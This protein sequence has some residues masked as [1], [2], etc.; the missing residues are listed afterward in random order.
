[1]RLLTTGILGMLVAAFAVAIH[2][3]DRPADAGVGA[4]QRAN[5]LLRVP[6]E[7]VSRI[8]IERGTS[9]VVLEQREGAWFFASPEVDRVD[10]RIVGSLLDELNHLGVV[11][12]LR[13]GEGDLS[14]V[15][16]GVQGDEAIQVLLAG[17]DERGRAFEEKVTLG[18]PAPRSG[19]LY[20]RRGS[21]EIAYVIDG[22]PRRF[23]ETPLLA[24][25]ES[26]LLTAPV[27]GIVQLG[28][29]RSGFEA[30][31]HRR[32]TPPRQDW[33]LSAPLDAWADPERMDRL[34]A[35]LASLRIEEVVAGEE[36]DLRVP[37]PLPENAVVFQARVHGV[38]QPITLYLF[39]VEP[40]PVE[41]APATLGAK[42][43]DRPGVYRLRST[44]L[45][46]LPTEANDL[47]NRKL[48][49]IPENYLD[50]I[51]IQ[52][53]SDPNVILRAQRREER[54]SWSVNLNNKL[55][56]ANQTEL[57]RLVQG[58]NEAAILGF[59]ADDTERRADFGLV[60]PARRITFQLKFPG[61][62]GPDGSPGQVQE[63]ERVLD[64]GWGGEGESMRLYANFHDEPFIHELDPSVMTL[65]A[66]H[67]LH[68]R[69]LAILS[70]NPFHLR[71]IT[72]ETYEREKLRLEYNYRLD[73]WKALR[74][75]VEI[76]TLDPMAARRLRD[77]IG[78]L[79]ATRWLVNVGT[80]HEALQTPSARFTVVTSELDPAIGQAAE[81][82]YQID[83]APAAAN[84]YY[85]QL[86]GSPDIFVIDHETYRELIRPVTGSRAVE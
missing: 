32:V 63:L 17:E 57:A 20:A 84:L 34:L 45:D 1:M 83:F 70:V 76:A 68:W 66:T 41:G 33:A 13:P 39:E 43:S 40:P 30:V 3:V 64:L 72:R 10:P 85:G 4:A 73:S 75:G 26:R 12:S 2:I 52:S 50:Q 23:L 25:R 65:V 16:L 69:S 74:N 77:R 18:V 71:S 19:A 15:R 58:L 44:L 80:A 31:V 42:V 62:P 82:S 14:P 28:L 60:P 79:S 8:E 86:D 6:T 38:E 24:L 22:N 35:D 61:A 11:D 36:P 54:V 37:D 29:R 59:A 5:V 67:P 51:I 56:P 55:V 47:R 27:E 49:A 21:E 46:R 53:P 78:S 9:K 48:A 81:R 7:A